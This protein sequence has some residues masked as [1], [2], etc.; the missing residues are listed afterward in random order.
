MEV[1]VSW[2]CRGSSFMCACS[3]GLGNAPRLGY[4]VVDKNIEQCLVTLLCGNLVQFWQ[5]RTT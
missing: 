2:K 4:M 5:G 1:A 3:F